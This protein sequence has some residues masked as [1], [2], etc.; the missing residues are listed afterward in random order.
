MA[1]TIPVYPEANQ[2]QAA[3]YELHEGTKV[4]L[5]DELNDW[6]EIR[7]SNGNRGWVKKAML[8]RL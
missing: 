4:Y 5:E 1:D 3:L 2:R 6:Q 7:L 8:K